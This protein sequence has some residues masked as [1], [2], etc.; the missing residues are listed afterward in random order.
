MGIETDSAGAISLAGEGVDTL[1][2]GSFVFGPKIGQGFY[3]NLMGNFEPVTIDLWFMRTWGRMTGT[4]IGN[5]T[6]TQK[7][8]EELRTL[9]PEEGIEFDPELFGTDLQYTFDTAT[10]LKTAGEDHYKAETE[11]LKAENL[12]K[13]DRIDTVSYTHLT[14]PTIYSV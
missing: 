9:M 1:V 7:N 4:L 10:R 13:E 5:D 11:R 8:I 6:A 2:Y 14:L 3:Q 12:T